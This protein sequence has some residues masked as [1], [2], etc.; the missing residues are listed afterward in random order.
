MKQ[1]L[2]I[3]YLL[4]L[5]ITLGACYHR[6][7]TVGEIIVDTDAPNKHNELLKIGFTLNDGGASRNLLTSDLL[8]PSTFEKGW[9]EWKNLG[10]SISFERSSE[11]KKNFQYLLKAIV[12]NKDSINGIQLKDSLAFPVIKDDE[13]IFKGK[14]YSKGASTIE[15]ALVSDSIGTLVS[16]KVMFHPTGDW[17]DVT[18]KLKVS[19]NSNIASLRLIFR[20]HEGAQILK[21]DST[22]KAQRQSSTIYLKSPSLKLHHNDEDTKSTLPHQLTQLL[23]GLKPS[24]LR[25]PSGSQ[26][27][28]SFPMFLDSLIKI[29]NK[30]PTSLTYKQFIKLSKEI[31]AVPIL[32]TDAGYNTKPT[33]YSQ[34]VREIKDPK[35]ILQLGYN[36]EGIEYFYRAH[37]IVQQLQSDSLP[38]HIINSG[39][40][41]PFRQ[42]S[43][44]PYDRALPPVRFE[45]LSKL[46]S[47][48]KAHDFLA[49]P[50]LLGEV[51]FQDST[52]TQYY[53]PPLVLRAAFLI[54]AERNSQYL[55]GIGVAPLLSEHPS[56]DY[57]LISV[58]GGHYVPSD[59]YQY[60][61]LFS[62]L[63]GEHLKS[64]PDHTPFEDGLIISLTSDS[65]EKD[66]YLKAVN[67]TRHPL[68]FLIKIKG[69]K[70][71][72][73]SADIHSFTLSDTTAADPMKEGKYQLISKKIEIGIRQ[74]FE[75]N[76]APFEI[77]II[78]FKQLD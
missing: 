24:F 59:Y 2:L 47:L 60:I 56:V 4:L 9:I 62:Q 72:I 75:Y 74:R 13:Y 71:K 76:F 20:T 40:I 7:P 5:S 68:P 15:I 29:E 50:Q 42:F 30:K 22:Y 39:S 63:R 37:A 1:K 18:A 16:N 19:E 21:P 54:L 36:S 78:H 41:L 49:E 55:E 57:P 26:T 52:S 38:F 77:V 8:S 35:V 64:M 65:Q 58:S 45:D 31:S 14:A 46:D 33:Y 23:S 12:S 32:L 6:Q 51:Y 43:D 61:Q 67:T 3:I 69:R 73:S 70:T 27:N 25:Y 10:G 53:I 11:E 66:F 17:S 34:L 48:I 28:N 44:Y